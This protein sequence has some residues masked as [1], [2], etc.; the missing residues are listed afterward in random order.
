MTPPT[1]DTTP[2]TANVPDTSPSAGTSDLDTSGAGD[3]ADDTSSSTADA[4]RALYGISRAGMTINQFGVL[5]RFHVPA[6]AM[7]PTWW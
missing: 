2:T 1:T 7:T 3:T 5:N 4:G 6:R